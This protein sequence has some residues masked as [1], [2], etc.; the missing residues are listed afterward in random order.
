MVAKKTKGL[1]EYLEKRDVELVILD[2][3]GD[4]PAYKEIKRLK[5]IDEIK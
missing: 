3:D 4:N 2:P 1:Y 5:D